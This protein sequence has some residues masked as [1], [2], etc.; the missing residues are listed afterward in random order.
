MSVPAH[1]LHLSIEEYLGYEQ[2]S[3]LRHEYVSGRI[4]A[5]TGASEAHNAIASNLHLQIGLIIRGS[6]CRAYLADMKLHVEATNSFYYPDLMV[7]CQKYS[8]ESQYKT[9]ANFIAEILSPST[10]DIDCREKLSAYRTIRTLMEYAVIYQSERRIELY[11]KNSDGN[12]ELFVFQ[13]HDNM[14]L[15]C[16]C[17]TES[18][19]PLDDIYEGVLA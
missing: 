9:E 7:T 6:G 19:I 3:Q 13:D 12:W 5:M 18:V 1:D 16:I 17:S 4:F 14:I 2:N 15:K 8:G 10:K 11:R